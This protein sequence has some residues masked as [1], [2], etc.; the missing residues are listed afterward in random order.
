MQIQPMDIHMHWVQSQHDVGGTIGRKVL[1]YAKITYMHQSTDVSDADDNIVQL[2]MHARRTVN[3]PD[4]TQSR[5][6]ILMSH[7]KT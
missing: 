1:S 2:H 3:N 4:V 5:M 6:P 7:W